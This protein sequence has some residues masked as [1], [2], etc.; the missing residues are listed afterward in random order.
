MITYRYD[1]GTSFGEYGE[2]CYKSAF[3][4]PV[5]ITTISR[6]SW[7]RKLWHREADTAHSEYC[8]FFWSPTASEWFKVLTSVVDLEMESGHAVI[9][10]LQEVSDVKVRR[11]LSMMWKRKRVWGEIEALEKDEA[12][13]DDANPDEASS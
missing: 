12:E 5:T 6:P 9:T 8:E 3:R 7:W 2:D 4:V 11:I 13:Y 1:F 10:Q